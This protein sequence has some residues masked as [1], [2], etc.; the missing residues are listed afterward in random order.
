MQ[1]EA[2]A[3]RREREATEQ[4]KIAARQVIQASHRLEEVAKDGRKDGS[5]DWQTNHCQYS[6]T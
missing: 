1:R 4:A 3:R 5:S 2:E 6:E